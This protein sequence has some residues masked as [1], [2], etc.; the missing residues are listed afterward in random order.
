MTK[1]GQDNDVTDCTSVV[2]EKNDIGLLHNWSYRCSLRWKHM[3]CKL[4][5]SF[6]GSKQAFRSWNKHFD[7]VVKTFG[8]DQN[9]N[10]PYVYKKV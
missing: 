1:T 7:Q 2:Y 9:K 4:H 3:V 5:K 10:E 8:F 6:Y